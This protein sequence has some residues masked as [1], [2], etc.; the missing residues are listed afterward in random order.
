MSKGYEVK[1]SGREGTDEQLM[2]RFR[3][4]AT[5]NAQPDVASNDSPTAIRARIDEMFQISEELKA[6]RLWRSRR[7]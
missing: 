4:L 5:V 2:Q 1:P 6:R 3:E 7:K